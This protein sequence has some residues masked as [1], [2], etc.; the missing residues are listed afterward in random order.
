M[1]ESFRELEHKREG[2]IIHV[3]TRSRTA[4]SD[5]RR[6]TSIR[7]RLNSKQFSKINRLISL[8]NLIGLNEGK[9]LEIDTFINF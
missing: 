8:K 9:N 2:T 5:N 4:K 7:G 3:K 6:R 1:E